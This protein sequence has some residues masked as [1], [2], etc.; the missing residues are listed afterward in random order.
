MPGAKEGA[1]ETLD[2]REEYK[3]WEKIPA[4]SWTSV[5][6]LGQPVLL[7]VAQSAAKRGLLMMQPV[8]GTSIA[9]SLLAIVVPCHW[10]G[11]PFPRN[12][13]CPLTEERFISD[14]KPEGQR[15][16]A[17]GPSPGLY[18]GKV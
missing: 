7:Y 2:K 16:P 4:L 10:S 3:A 11:T 5:Q 15:K 12:L 14:V 9:I 17:D 1:W 13:V 6:G 8:L 18:G